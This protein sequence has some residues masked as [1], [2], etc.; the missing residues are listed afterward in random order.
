MSGIG[1]SGTREFMST[2]QAPRPSDVQPVNTEGGWAAWITFAGTMLILLGCFHVVQGLVALFRDEVYL[3]G[4]SGLA[5]NVDYTVWGWVHMVGG[6]VAVLAGISLIRGR[7]WARILAVV[8]AFASAILNVAFLPA[9]PIWAALMI[10]VDIV[11]IW[12]VIIHGAEMKEPE[13]PGVS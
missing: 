9:Y 6:V 10:T 12:A 4:R 11:V 3:V 5:V 2:G 7:M 8:V 13:L 1:M